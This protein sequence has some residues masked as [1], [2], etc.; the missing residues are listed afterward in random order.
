MDVGGGI[1]TVSMALTKMQPQLNL[2]V[3]DRASVVADGPKRWSDSHGDVL[4]SGRVVFQG[5]CL[6]LFLPLRC[7]PIPF[8][9]PA[10][11]F[12]QPQPVQ[13]AAAYLLKSI[14]HDWSDPYA[15]QILTRIREAAAP[16]SK[17]LVIDRI[18]PYACRIAGEDVEALNALGIETEDVPEPLPPNLGAGNPTAYATDLNVRTH[19]ILPSPGSSCRFTDPLDSPQML[20]LVNGQERTIGHFT[21]LFSASRWKIVRVYQSGSVQFGRTHSLI[22]A[23]PV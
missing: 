2:V 21:E 7:L 19:F 23:A 5:M 4:A 9:L 14:I 20:V 10:H 1:G 3:Q 18:L 8:S 11:D 16:D 17:L 15:T 22:E 12:F 13:G 6:S